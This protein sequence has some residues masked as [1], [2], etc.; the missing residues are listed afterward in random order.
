MP[1]SPRRDPH[2]NTDQ[3]QRRESVTMATIEISA[4]R[5]LIA[6]GFAIAV[7]A[8][9]AVATFTFA[10]AASPSVLACPNGEST[11]IYN[12][13]CIPD[14]VPNSPTVPQGVGVDS[15]GFPTVDGVPCAGHNSGQ[16]IGLA[17]EQ[18]S[19]GPAAV[20]HSSL[21]GQPIG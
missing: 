12:G 15:D 20:P 6:G 4:R 11:D 18:A 16:C 13:E 7:A 1:L 2:G 9:P 8:A 3:E 14:L 17:D 10:P 19:E 5:L 21:N